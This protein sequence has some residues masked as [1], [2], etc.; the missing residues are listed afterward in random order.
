M[1]VNDSIDVKGLATSGGS[2]ALENNFPRA[3]S[4]L[5]AKLEAAGAVILGDT[6]I[7]EL[8]GYFDP[9]M[10]QG[11]SSL[12]GQV[13]LPSDTN[14]SVGGSSGGSTAAVSAGYAPLAIGSETSPD[15]AGLITPA[16]NAGLVALKPTV[17]LVSRTGCYPSRSRRTRPGRSVR[18]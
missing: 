15:S 5:V 17:G 16:A 11:Y 6:N 7:T 9:N 8:N 18:P 12:G 14:K 4:T 3:D 1:L 10:P 2:I 13:L